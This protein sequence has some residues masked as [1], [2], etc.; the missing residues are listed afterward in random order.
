[1]FRFF[2]GKTLRNMFAKKLIQNQPQFVR[3]G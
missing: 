3:I 2:S 1:M